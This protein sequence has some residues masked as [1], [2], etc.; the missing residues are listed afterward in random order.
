MTEWAE[1][2]APVDEPGA[3][4]DDTR[5][6]DST[7]SPPGPPAWLP[8]ESSD[9][10]WR[11]RRA[12]P[13]IIAVFGLMGAVIL[14]VVPVSALSEIE[15]TSRR[16]I[17]LA[18]LVTGIDPRSSNERLPAAAAPATAAPAAGAAGGAAACAV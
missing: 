4:S 6:G 3:S 2:A 11:Y 16:T 7:A 14:L 8:P 12:A 9:A 15:P 18:S 17:V 1:Q 5:S 13:W 10:M